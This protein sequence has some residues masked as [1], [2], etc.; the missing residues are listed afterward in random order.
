MVEVRGV[1]RLRA[2][3]GRSIRHAAGLTQDP[4]PRCDDP[5]LAFGDVNGVARLVHRELPSMLVGGLG[6]L[7]L[8]ML[9]PYAM[10][11]VAEHSHYQDDPLAR[12]LQT[13]NFIGATTFGSNDTAQAAIE[14]VLFVHAHVHGVA[15]DGER[16]DANDPH[17]LLWVHC[18]EISMFLGAYQ[19]FGSRRL[20]AIEADHYVK[21]TANVA[22][23]L[24]VLDPP[25]TLGE[26]HAAILSFR[27]ELR[28]SPDGALARDFLTRRITTSRAQRVVYWLLVRS[29]WALLPNYA[30]DLLG[31]RAR[32]GRERLV[33]R[34]LTSTICA[35]M[36]LVVP[37]PPHV[38]RV[39]PPSTAST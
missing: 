35:L 28:L 25:E 32:G 38:A 23:R 30:Q 1:S 5:A 3:L 9:H 12:V 22:R 14:R 18:A 10:A 37:P 19:R 34:P 36:R 27:G 11:G 21:E 6:S 4:P 7:F 17:L 39:S 29:S 31:V 13:A 26:L 16:Y 2:R 24:G 15:D 33:V 20:D 8:Q